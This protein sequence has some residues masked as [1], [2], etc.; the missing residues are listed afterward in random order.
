[1]DMLGAK[2]LRPISYS[3]A[4]SK[5]SRTISLYCRLLGW[6]GCWQRHWF[7]PV[8]MVGRQLETNITPMSPQRQYDQC[9]ITVL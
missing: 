7:Q 8:E 2:T 6:C 4:V 9:S 5:A 1:M 3:H